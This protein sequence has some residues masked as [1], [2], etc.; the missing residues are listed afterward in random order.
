MLQAKVGWLPQ[1]ILQELPEGQ[2]WMCLGC[3]DMVGPGD[4]GP[5]RHLC[6]AWFFLE[7]HLLGIRET[8]MRVKGSGIGEG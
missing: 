8:F 6:F 3:L 4:T 7:E 5:G 2:R 1:C